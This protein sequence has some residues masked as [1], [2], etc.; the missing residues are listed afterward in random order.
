M[1]YSPGDVPAKGCACTGVRWC[2][3]CR[4]R[5]IRQLHRMDDP[6][7][8]P[9]WLAI[10]PTSPDSNPKARHCIHDFDLEL[11]RA[12]SCPDFEGVRVFREFFSTSEAERLLREIEEAPFIPA[13]S[14]KWKQH[15]GPKV[16]FNKQ[17]INASQFQGLPDY[18]FRIESRLRELVAQDRLGNSSNRLALRKALEGFESTDAFVLRY[19]E[20]DASN[21]DMHRDDLF[22]YGEAILDV[23]LESDSVLTFLERR[24]G[25]AGMAA[26]QCVRVPLPARSLAVLHGRARFTWDHAILAY[27]IAGRRTS[28]TLRTLSDP[29]R[30]TNEGRRIIGIMR[31][32][33]RG[34][35]PPA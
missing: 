24:D 27:D 33:V 20:Q 21:L 17:R 26:A 32:V 6:V 34:N 10:R 16:N 22:A 5:G 13:Q 11:Q 18:A 28:I 2:A 4:D 23:S 30:N 15:Y 25:D 12:P 35:L 8:L 3:G 14:G 19:H 29:L 31:G 7:R 1:K 9:D